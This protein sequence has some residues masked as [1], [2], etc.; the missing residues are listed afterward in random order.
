MIAHALAR[1]FHR[2]QSGFLHLLIGFL[3]LVIIVA[4]A[5]VIN[6]GEVVDNKLQAQRAADAAAYSASV[7]QS[8]AINA[9]TGGNIVIVR[10]ASAEAL[11]LAV[12]PTASRIYGNWAAA[13]SASPW[14]AG[15]VAA[16][17]VV[18]AEFLASTGQTALREELTGS[19]VRKAKRV[20]RWQG[21]VV[22]SVPE[23]IEA[24]RQR[25]EEIYGTEI[26]LSQLGPHPDLVRAPIRKPRGE[27]ERFLAFA[28]LVE[29]RIRE[30]RAG[31]ERTLSRIVI[32]R[33][34][35]EWDAATSEMGLRVAY[36]L[37]GKFHV[38]ETQ[39][40][41]LERK[42]TRAQRN[43]AFAVTAV[44]RLRSDVE[45]PFVLSRV[46]NRRAE[47]GSDATAFAQAE[48]YHP[49]DEGQILP[50]QWRVWSF[51]GWQWEPRLTLARAM[52]KLVQSDDRVA[53]VMQLS[54]SP[55]NDPIAMQTLIKH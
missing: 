27:A 11:A 42:P 6:A 50:P 39:K 46:F 32:G 25:L 41:F 24:D 16:E 2:S 14:L 10:T 48:T 7:V 18:L 17:K 36:E 54:G 55:T 33:G 53:E 45:S 51:A 29:N 13:L 5:V 8:E 35:A 30:D 1:R 19:L 4:L 49:A 28:S 52:P 38:L 37:R 47:R 43:Y 9:I 15:A 22:A 20:Y 26:I 21:D 40:G 23:V 3:F 44:A 34:A 12:R 31:W